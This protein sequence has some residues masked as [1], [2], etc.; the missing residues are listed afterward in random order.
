MKNK[1]TKLVGQAKDSLIALYVTENKAR[2]FDGPL[3]DRKRDDV[4]HIGIE[5]REDEEHKAGSQ[6][7]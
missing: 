2:D 1:S 5:I 4:N 7:L 6:N 3:E